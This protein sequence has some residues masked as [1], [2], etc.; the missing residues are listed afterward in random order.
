M[1]TLR[2][3]NVKNIKLL[4]SMYKHIKN[5]PRSL[6]RPSRF[7]TRTTGGYSVIF[8]CHCYGGGGFVVKIFLTR[9]R[10][11][12]V[13]PSFKP[14][15]AVGTVRPANGAKIYSLQLQETYHWLLAGAGT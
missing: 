1:D 5:F 2:I 15:S 10:A 6:I 13:G 11:P 8:T 14:R 9:E 3:R 7:T 12:N 4:R